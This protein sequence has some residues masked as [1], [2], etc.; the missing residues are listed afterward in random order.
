MS[1]YR[2]KWFLQCFLIHV[3]GNYVFAKVVKP[4][5]SLFGTF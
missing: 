3:A 5:F 2:M 1:K 4:F